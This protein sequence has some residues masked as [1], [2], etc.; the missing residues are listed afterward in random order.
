M[1]GVFQLKQRQ[2]KFCIFLKRRLLLLS[3]QLYDFYF[4]FITT[5]HAL[6]SYGA[7]ALFNMPQ[8]ATAVASGRWNA[9]LKL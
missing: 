3:E 4:F 1:L 7:I 5:L 6:V 2:N 8:K 9:S